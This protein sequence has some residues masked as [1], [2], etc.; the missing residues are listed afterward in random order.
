LL[1]S[2]ASAEA[3]ALSGALVAACALGHERVG[4]LL[5]STIRDRVQP[6]RPPHAA[7][8]SLWTHPAGALHAASAAGCAPLVLALLDGGSAAK[9]SVGLIDGRSRLA[10]LAHASAAGAVEVVRLLLQRAPPP[11][12]GSDGSVASPDSEGRG[13]VVERQARA[14]IIIHSLQLREPLSQFAKFELKELALEVDLPGDDDESQFKLRPISVEGGVRVPSQIQ[15]AQGQ[16]ALSQSAEGQPQLQTQPTVW[17]CDGTQLQTQ[18]AVKGHA[19]GGAAAQPAAQ[20]AAAAAAVAADVFAV[21]FAVGQV[22][23]APMSVNW[24]PPEEQAEQSDAPGG[25]ALALLRAGL[26]GGGSTTDEINLFVNGVGETGQSKALAIGYLPCLSP[27]ERLRVRLLN[28]KEEHEVGS[29]EVSLEV[30]W[31]AAG[32]DTDAH[33]QGFGGVHAL[34]AA[35]P[36]GDDKCADPNG[37]ERAPLRRTA[38]MLAVGGWHPLFSE[39]NLFPSETGSDKTR[40]PK[41]VLEDEADARASV[42]KELLAANAD[43][44]LCD[45]QGRTALHYAAAHARGKKCLSPLLE[46]MAGGTSGADAAG[47]ARSGAAGTAGGAAGAAGTAGVGGASLGYRAGPLESVDTE[48]RTPLLLAA[49]AGATESALEALR[50]GADAR[51]RDARRR[52]CLQLAAAG[53]HTECLE[54]LLSE[55]RAAVAAGDREVRAA[56][57][58][59]FAAGRTDAARMLFLEV[60]AAEAEL[61]AVE[62]QAEAQGGAQPQPLPQAGAP[63]GAQPQPQ[64]PP[65]PQPQPQPQAG[66]PAGAQPPQPQPPQPPPQPQPPQPGGSLAEGGLA[67]ENDSSEVRET[68]R[69]ACAAARAGADA[70]VQ[71]L[72]R[73][74]TLSGLLP[75]PGLPSSP[76][77]THGLGAR[78]LAAEWGALLHAAVDG[79]STGSPGVTGSVGYLSRTLPAITAI[80]NG[81]LSG[82][83][84]TSRVGLAA[85]LASVAPLDSLLVLRAGA[86]PLGAAVAAGRWG[87]HAQLSKAMTQRLEVRVEVVFCTRQAQLHAAKGERL[88]SSRAERTPAQHAEAACKLLKER[89][90]GLAVAATGGG[91]VAGAFELLVAHVLTGETHAASAEPRLSRLAPEPAAAEGARASGGRRVSSLAFSRLS[92]GRYPTDE[93]LVGA[94]VSRLEGEGTPA[95]TYVPRALR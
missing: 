22:N 2:A 39:S 56:L 84:L 64:P 41:A 78:E 46:A 49:A 34:L 24:L 83:V 88:S 69:F 72:L 13:G 86:T 48:G 59:A 38:L 76:G 32:A 26:L 66:A 7:P 90:P 79:G 67:N 45:S 27:G 85:S 12:R 43:S 17:I 33:V 10:P 1:L 29:I 57:A 70:I 20:P 77:L 9:P 37:R 25:A 82:A 47:E 93:E 63:A 4:T 81:V 58:S 40:N 42:V 19:K 75:S 87:V 11:K 94:L 71:E 35:E 74:G 60:E 16:S 68:F 18:P 51:S 36:A 8:P 5:L 73:R 15:T 61:E 50:L 52:G 54:M 23:S 80:S 14:K 6:A 44:S 65:Q 53:G 21:E 89:W 55:P 28:E 92:A 91:R 95:V 31:Q 3:A 62:A 30:S